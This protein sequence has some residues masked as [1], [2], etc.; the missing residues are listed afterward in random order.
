MDKIIG[1]LLVVSA[2]ATVYLSYLDP[3][4]VYVG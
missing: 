4:R 2:V 1:W 3:T